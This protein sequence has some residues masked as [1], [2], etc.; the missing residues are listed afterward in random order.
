MTSASLPGPGRAAMR[1][2]VAAAPARR[3]HRGAA[4][5]PFTVSFSPASGVFPV[6]AALAYPEQA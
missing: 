4:Y 6:T 3:A 2:V 5:R 1:T